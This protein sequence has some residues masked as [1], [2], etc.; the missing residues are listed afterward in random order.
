MIDRRKDDMT[1]L[2]HEHLACQPLCAAE[3]SMKCSFDITEISQKRVY[4]APFPP[5]NPDRRNLLNV[6]T[7]LDRLHGGLNTDFVQ[8][9]LPLNRICH[10]FA[11][12][13]ESER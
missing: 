3:E 2:L 12:D 8:F 1:D 10:L 7:H 13:L 6:E 9:P 4:A 11:Q 5:A